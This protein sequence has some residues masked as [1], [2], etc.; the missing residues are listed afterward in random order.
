LTRFQNQACFHFSLVSEICR[1]LYAIS[2]K[3]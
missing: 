3:T 1:Q 2:D